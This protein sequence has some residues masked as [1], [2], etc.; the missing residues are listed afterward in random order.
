MSN[1]NDPNQK[2][3]NDKVKELL[4]RAQKFRGIQF[5]SEKKKKKK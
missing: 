1:N 3:S 4:K 5:K 2:E